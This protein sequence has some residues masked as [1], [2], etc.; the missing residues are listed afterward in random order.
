MPTFQEDLTITGKLG[1][2]VSKPA[3]KLHVVGDRIRLENAGKKLDLRADG[4]QVDLQTET[5]DLYIR[6]VG[7][8]HDILMNPIAG[9]GN[10]I[11]G[12]GSPQTKLDVRGNIVVSGDIVLQNADCAEEFD[13]AAAVMVEPG[14]VMVLNEEGQ[15]AQSTQA[16]DKRVAGVVS[17]AGDFK[18]ALVLDRQ[19]GQTDRAAIALMGKVY[20]KVDAQYAAIAVGDLLTTSPTPGC[21]MKATDAQR[22]FGA[23][24]GK[25]LR[26]LQAGAGLIPVLVTLQ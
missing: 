1:L 20:C 24:L 25:A 10:V 23:I 13:V 2:G 4:S 18:P 19:S 8:G 11:I 3:T 21:A 7:P 5:N 16:Y 6:S 12:N 26:P 9:D 14:A 15:L 22:A 17:G